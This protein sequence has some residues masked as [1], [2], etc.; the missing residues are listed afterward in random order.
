MGKGDETFVGIM[1]LEFS[2][3]NDSL[4]NT[5]KQTESKDVFHSVPVA[6]GRLFH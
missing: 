5:K 3:V 6:L 1:A 2:V 4:A